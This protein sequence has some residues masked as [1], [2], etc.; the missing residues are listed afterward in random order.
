MATKVLPDIDAAVLNYARI[1][2]EHGP[3]SIQEIENREKLTEDNPEL[4]SLFRVMRLL[5]SSR[6][7]LL[8]KFQKE[9]LEKFRGLFKSWSKNIPSIQ[10]E[11]VKFLD[12]VPKKPQTAC[13][14]QSQKVTDLAPT[15]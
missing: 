4:A 9:D 15:I 2:R 12:P 7:L 1:L 8:K 3:Y 11:L 14:P 6:G 10:S 13:N 5:F